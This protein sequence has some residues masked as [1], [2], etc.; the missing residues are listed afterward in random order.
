MN[1]SNIE[2][3]DYTWNPIVGCSF[4]C[5]YCYARK[6]NTR[7]NKASDFD[8][9]VF[10]PDRLKLPYKFKKPSKIFVGSMCDIFSFGVEDSWIEQILQVVRDNPHHTFQFLSKASA[11]FK[12]FDIPR[13]VWLGTSVSQ[14]S[15]QNQ[16]RINDLTSCGCKYVT[17]ALVEPLLGSMQYMDM[18]AIDFVFVGALTGP[19]ATPPLP[20]WI[21]SIKHHNIFW[22]ENIKKYL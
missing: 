22:K 20:E 12:R 7:F 13:N 5:S 3:C 18:S 8:T 17:F 4:S 14:W 19:G 16:E 2:F 6:F 11:H 10:H 9:P 1:R 21:Q 15:L